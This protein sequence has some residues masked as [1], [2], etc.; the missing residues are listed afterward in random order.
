MPPPGLV[1]TVAVGLAG[2]QLP[3]RVGS[4]GR[5]RQLG[6]EPPAAADNLQV[7]SH[8][9]PVATAN[10]RAAWRKARRVPSLRNSVVPLRLTSVVVSRS[11]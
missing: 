10:G 5:M 7:G 1:K 2:G 8:L 9:A 11:E 6:R 3:G 4:A